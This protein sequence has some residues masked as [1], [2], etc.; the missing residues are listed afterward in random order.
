MVSV[1]NS[2][3]LL[4]TENGTVREVRYTYLEHMTWAHPVTGARLEIEVPR[5]DVYFLPVS[6]Q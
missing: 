2:D 4:E 5:E 3:E 6:L 1:K